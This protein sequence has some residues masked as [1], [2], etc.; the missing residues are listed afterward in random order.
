MQRKNVEPFSHTEP[1]QWDA[2]IRLPLVQASYQRKGTTTLAH[3]KAILASIGSRGDIFPYLGLG[4]ALIERGYEVSLLTTPDYR[5]DTE[6]AGIE[7][8]E[9]LNADDTDHVKQALISASDGGKWRLDERSRQIF[10][11]IP[12]VFHD[13]IAKHSRPGDTVLLTSELYTLG[14][15]S[16]V[17]A[18]L[19]IPYVSVW[20]APAFFEMVNPIL[21]NAFR[22]MEDWGKNSLM[23]FGKLLP[24]MKG[25]LADL[26][27]EL[28]LPQEPNFVRELVYSQRLN[29]CLYPE[30][31]NS[32]SVRMTDTLFTGFPQFEPP[33]DLPTSVQA[34]LNDGDAPVVFMNASW[35]KDLA[36]F[37]RASA[38]ACRQLG[39]R[40]VMI[41]GNVPEDI[42]RM[43]NV[44]AVDFVPLQTLLKHSRALVHH[45]GIGTIGAAL[46]VGTLQLLVPF[47]A[48]QPRNAR[49]IVR[50]GLGLS[51]SDGEYQTESQ[52][53]LRALLGSTEIEKNVRAKGIS[54]AA[55]ADF[56]T[57]IDRVEALLEYQR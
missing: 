50:L 48:D 21:P 37:Y 28:S 6:A 42:A 9:L 1:R 3:L 32:R 35:R 23:R 15:G 39:L 12:R 25:A 16:I 53:Q 33:G 4:K 8:L 10:W 57:A 5:S 26:R 27:R 45:A 52:S 18:S 36:G 30:V 51:V 34:F 19:G 46:N 44:C 2:L 20:Q 38:E 13:M 56:N 29:L 22:G 43:T 11:G 7:Y 54:L 47:S 41:G 31:F 14:S 24:R 40:A 49:T 55:P 17:Q